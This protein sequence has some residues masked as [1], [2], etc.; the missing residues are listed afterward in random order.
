MGLPPRQITCLD[1][2]AMRELKNG[3]AEAGI[4]R[5]LLAGLHARLHFDPVRF[6]ALLKQISEALDQSRHPRTSGAPSRMSWDWTCSPV[7]WSSRIP[8]HDATCR[9]A[10][11]RLIRSPDDCILLPLSLATLQGPTTISGFGAGSTASAAGSTAIRPHRHSVRAGRP[12]T[13][14]QAGSGNSPAHWRRRQSH[15]RIPTH[16]SSFSLLARRFF[17][18]R[19]SME[20]CKR[21][22]PLLLRYT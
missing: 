9:V 21:A 16:G 20:C 11:T 19:W 15:D 10:A 5:T 8:V 17:A 7:S 12:M 3:L 22:D 4:G 14:G 6:S 1:D 13:T 2:S 18:A